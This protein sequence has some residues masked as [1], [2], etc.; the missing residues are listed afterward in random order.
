MTTKVLLFGTGGVGAVYAYFLEKGG[1][2]VTAVCRSNYEAVLQNGISIDSALFGQ[3][4]A[5]PSVARTAA[6]AQK[7][8]GP[9]DYIVVCAKAFPEIHTLISAAVSPKTAIVLCQNGINIEAP[10]AAAYPSN[11]IISGVVYLPVTQTRPGHI[12]MGPLQKLHIGPFPAPGTP[13][14]QEQ[15]QKFAKIFEAGGG[16]IHVHPDVQTQRWLKLALNFALNPMCALTRLD[17]ANMYRSSATMPK[18]I[19]DVMTELT[20]VARAAGYEVSLELIQEQLSRT[21]ERQETGG[22][23]PSML[24]DVRENRALEVDAILGNAVTIA[25]QLGLETPRM[26]LLYALAQGL[27]YSIAPDERFRPLGM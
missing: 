11:T 13:S 6:E 12:R 9:F 24:T 20:T 23:E 15:T 19:L 14:A 1:A 2:S 25:R 18:A 26:D 10:Y 21:K 5:H 22:K 8:H 17:D 4:T 27:S 3:V 7:A 16:V